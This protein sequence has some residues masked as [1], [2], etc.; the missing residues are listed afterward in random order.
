M[1]RSEEAGKHSNQLSVTQNK[2]AAES[3]Q[4]REALYPAG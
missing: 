4:C 3:A 2:F 1:A